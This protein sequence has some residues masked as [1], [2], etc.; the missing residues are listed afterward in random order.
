MLVIG[1]VAT[2]WAFEHRVHGRTLEELATE[3]FDWQPGWE[4][5]L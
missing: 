3:E 1:H 2:H 4:Y 5:A